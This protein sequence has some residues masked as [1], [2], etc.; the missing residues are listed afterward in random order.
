MDP[1]P[2]RNPHP[3]EQDLPDLPVAPDQA[4]DVQGGK[5]KPLLSKNLTKGKPHSSVE[6]TGAP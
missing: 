4:A 1:K 3:A 2:S 6:S 5:A